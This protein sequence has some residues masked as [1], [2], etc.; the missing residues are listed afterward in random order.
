MFQLL[1][2]T[3]IS[4]PTGH[5]IVLETGRGVYV[6]AND[7]GFYI[8][9]GD[10]DDAEAF[11]VMGASPDALFENGLVD[12]FWRSNEERMYDLQMRSYLESTLEK[13]GWDVTFELDQMRKEMVAM[14]N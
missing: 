12:M 3:A 6:Q 2:V 13:E 7:G 10:V 14:R 4:I 11:A 1:T 8:D 5:A 9:D